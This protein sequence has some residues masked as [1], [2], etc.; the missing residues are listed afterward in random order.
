MAKNLWKLG[1]RY[2]K[3]NKSVFGKPNLTFKKI[4]NFCRP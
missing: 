2:R 3:N 1:C 4:C